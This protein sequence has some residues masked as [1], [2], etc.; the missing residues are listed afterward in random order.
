MGFVC[1]IITNMIIPKKAEPFGFS[2]KYYNC[3]NYAA[4][5][6]TNLVNEDLRF[7]ALFL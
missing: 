1:N 2:L 4:N 6:V 3:N 5:E 7:E